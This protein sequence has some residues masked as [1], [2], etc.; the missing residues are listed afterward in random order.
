MFI[1]EWI[2]SYD[3]KKRVSKLAQKY[4]AKANARQR[5]GRAG[6]VQEGVCFHLFSNQR[7]EFVG[8]SIK[9]KNQVT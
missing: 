5:R 6:R 2:F 3:D 1:Y 4:V 7:Y 9:D 8:I